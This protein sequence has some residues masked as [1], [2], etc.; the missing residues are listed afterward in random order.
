MHVVNEQTAHSINESFSKFTSIILLQNPS[1]HQ[2]KT[3]IQMFICCCFFLFFVFVFF[4]HSVKC[5]VHHCL[6]FYLLAIVLFVLRRFI[7]SDYPIIICNLVCKYIAFAF[8]TLYW[9]YSI[10]HN[11]VQFCITNPERNKLTTIMN[12]NIK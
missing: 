10:S 5:F 7:T 6:S 11:Y 9:E 4:Q 2:L 3:M 8:T 12:N 1:S